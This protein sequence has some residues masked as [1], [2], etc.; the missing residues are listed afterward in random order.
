MQIV[1]KSDQKCDNWEI[2][3][4]YIVIPKTILVIPYPYNY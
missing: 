4:K 2:Q 3:A 1:G